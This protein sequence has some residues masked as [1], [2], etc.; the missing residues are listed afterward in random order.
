MEMKPRI[1]FGSCG[2]SVLAGLLAVIGGTSGAAAQTTDS[3]ATTPPSEQRSHPAPPTPTQAL[4]APPV[5]RLFG[6]WFGLQPKL[7]SRGINLQLDALTE[8]ASNVTGGTRHVATFANQVGIQLDINWERLAGITGLSTHVIVVNRSGNSASR[9]FGDNLLP[10]QEIYGSGGD[11]I[12]HLVS[13]YAQETLLGGRLDIAVGR[14]NVENDFASS[15]LYCNFMNNGLCGDPKALP[16]GDIGH[17]AYP[18]GVWAARVRVRPTV[19]TYIETGV[20]EVNRGLYSN[21][22]FRTGFKFDTSQDSGVYLPV[23][24]A[25]EPKLGPNKLPGHYKLGFG[26][27]TSSGFQDFG[28]GLAA[29][30]VPGFTTQNRTGNF[31]GWLLVDQML[32]RNGTGDDE[33]VIGL[34]G[35]IRNDSN[36][37]VYADQYF[38]GAVDRGFW[39]A[40]PQ[41]SVGLLFSYVSASGRLAHVEAAEQSLGLPL[42]N[43]AT[44]VQSY[45]M[46]LEASYDISVYRG[47]TFQPDFQYIFRPNAQANIKDAAVF[48]FRAHVEF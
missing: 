25:W 11:V 42:S 38:L 9:E 10:V 6:D 41:D 3:G 24:A 35:Y 33:G 22:N 31:Q 18:E 19:E 2:F 16:G 47:V 44:G 30:S 29:S 37:T 15:S 20:Y 1:K 27:D 7:Q 46:L 12:A 21:A 26:Y 13:I 28:N 5:D 48:G 39:Q 43:S 8:F 32:M 40:R 45:E 34:A 4:D 14:M 17:S 36:N 23:E